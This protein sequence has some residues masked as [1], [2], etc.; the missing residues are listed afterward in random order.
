MLLSLKA[1]PLF[2]NHSEK[3]RLLFPR[4]KMAT[5][6]QDLPWNA[7]PKEQSKT[8]AKHREP[9]PAPG[10]APFRLPQSTVALTSSRQVST[11]QKVPDL[12]M[13]ALQ[14]TT[15]GPCA[16][17][18]EPDSRTLNRKFRNDAGD[19]GTPKSGQVV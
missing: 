14:C 15:T 18:S 3:L 10:P 4:L 5:E 6:E 2:V 7:L 9:F 12:P 17:L 19:S 11:R 16:G 1:K 8:T 13:P